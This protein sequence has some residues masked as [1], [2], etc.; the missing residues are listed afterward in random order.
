MFDSQKSL[1]SRIIPLQM[2]RQ[3][4][5]LWRNIAI[6]CEE[7]KIFLDEESL[8]NTKQ[9]ETFKL[10]VTENLQ[11]LLLVEKKI[12]DFYYQVNISFS[13]EIIFNF[14]QQILERLNPEIQVKLTKLLGQNKS[15][16]N[17][18]QE[19]IF[20][21]LEIVTAPLEFSQKHDYQLANFQPIELILRNRIEQE[22]ILK[23][24]THQIQ[25]NLDLLVI[26]KMTIEQVQHL[27]EIDRLIIYQFDVP[28]VSE[29]DKKTKKKTLVDAITYE[30]RAS[31]IIP[32]ILNLQGNQEFVQIYKNKIEYS[33]GFSLTINDISDSNL[34]SSTQQLMQKLGVKA[35]IVV[36]ILVKNKLWG[37][38]IAH[39]CFSSRKW[40]QGEI[41]FLEHIAEYLAVAIYQSNSYQQLQ[42]QKE[43]LEQKVNQRARQLQDALLAAQIAH[44]SKNEFLGNISHEL[45]TPLTCVI[46]LSGTLLHWSNEHENLSPEKQKH[47]LEVI[48]ESG[49]KLLHLINNILDFAEIESGKSLLKM[50]EFSL[51]HLCKKILWSNIEIAEKK[52]IKL[53][54]DFQIKPEENNFYADPERLMQ[55]MVNLLENAIKF[56]DN[57]GEVNFRVWKE[58][59]HVVFEVEDTGIGIYQEQFPLLF[60]KFQQLENYRTRIHGGT[61]LGLALT[62]HLVEL[63]GGVIEVDSVVGKGSSFTVRIPSYLPEK[64]SIKEDDYYQY[65][66]RNKT[67]II[68]SKDEEIATLICELLTVAEYQI[69]WLFDNND[70]VTKIELLEP[71]LII[72]HE[73]ISVIRDINKKL[74]LLENKKQAKVMI[75]CQEMKG[76]DWQNLSEN[77]IDDYLLQP[78]QPAILLKK[79][80]QLIHNS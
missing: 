17:L 42:K 27:L 16:S 45:R 69:I 1:I 49:K 72:L 28:R 63:H 77:G 21:L 74:K 58:N 43:M 55:I 9:S 3:L 54:L 36:P 32:S 39:Q 23:Q 59:N 50:E 46:G 38:L 78:L 40:K 65:N 15:C 57:Q 14:S 47:Y 80:S 2:F 11:G 34:D 30:A 51:E 22:K 60:N 6:K 56:T 25:Q 29:I 66:P 70:V 19:F 79:I 76:Y 53:N 35:K 64:E 37:L 20:K 31:D 24:V 26:V 4:C 7:E 10:I 62:K 52:N 48:Q 67:I 8:L 61:G 75:V 68:V 73:K 41:K 5:H 33:E 44:Q 13:Q 12:S 18:Q 71:Q